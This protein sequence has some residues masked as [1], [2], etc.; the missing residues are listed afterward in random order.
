MAKHGSPLR[1]LYLICF[2][3]VLA[4]TVTGRLL[5]Q[6]L[7]ELTPALST[8]AAPSMTETGTYTPT[9]TRRPSATP[10]PPCVPPLGSDAMRDV[11]E[12]ADSLIPG[13]TVIWYDDFICNDLSY[14]WGVGS[15][16]PNTTVTVSDGVMTFSTRETQDIWDGIN[17]MEMS[18]QDGSGIL[19]LFRFWNQTSANFFIST[20]TWWESD[21]R[22]WGFEIQKEPSLAGTWVGWAGIT[23]FTNGYVPTKILVPQNWYYLL[24]RLEE[25]GR[26]TM[27]LWDKE[28]P[29]NN[30]EFHQILDSS[31]TGHRWGTLFQVYDGTIQIDRYWEAAFVGEE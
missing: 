12:E 25:T 20:G 1:V 7:D 18:I 10:T 23:G 28:Q 4:C 26:V 22:R 16:N 24:I 6:P 5:P 9:V 13:G 17:R 19:V 31:W 30:A 3:I 2:P 11:Q 27:K 15:I 8:T 29:G 21:Y 14:G